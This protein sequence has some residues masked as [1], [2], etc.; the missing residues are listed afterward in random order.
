MFLAASILAAEEPTPAATAA[1]NSYV[2]KVEARLDGQHRVAEGFLAAEDFARLQ[3]G[4]VIIEQLTPA[5]G[6]IC[7]E[8]FCTIGAARRLCREPKPPTL[9]G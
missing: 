4:E 5:S 8:P 3:R 6:R 1:F 9:S 7:R 2:S